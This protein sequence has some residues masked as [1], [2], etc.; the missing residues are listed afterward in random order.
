MSDRRLAVFAF[1]DAFGWEILQRNPFLEEEL[2]HRAPVETVFG[3]SST[4]I[5]TILTGC[6]PREHGHFSCFYYN[7]S[8]SPFGLCRTLSLLPKSVT[9]RGRVRRYLSKGLARWYGYDGYFQIYNMPFDKLPYFDY[10]EKRDLYQP[11]GIENGQPTVFD[12]FRQ[13]R[14]PFHLSNWRESET[15]N[16]EAA[17]QD[18]EAGGVRA[19]Y[20]YFYELDAVLHNHGP[21]A[22]QVQEKIAWYEEQLRQ[23]LHTARGRYDEVRLFVFSDHGQAA[24]TEEAD[25]MPRVDR[26]GLRYGQDYAVVWDSTMGRFWFFHDEARE[27]IT[28]ALNGLDCGAWVDDATLERWGCDFPDG[29]YGHAFFL[30]RPGVLINPSYMGEVRL[31]GMHG[32]TPEDR[33]STA[34]IASSHPPAVLPRRL[35]DHYAMMVA[36]AEWAAGGA[37]GPAPAPPVPAHVPVKREEAA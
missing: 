10:S 23:L 36:E 20:L 19:V 17:V 6:M 27:A 8:G 28:E 1:I 16:L 35:D 37:G 30:V 14:L 3:Y 33:D 15:R 29:K 18:I 4:C 24:I 13:T 7:P 32:Y 22:P 34:M 21:E 31:A 25:L 9:R 5:P 26:L 11:G 2:P 12:Y